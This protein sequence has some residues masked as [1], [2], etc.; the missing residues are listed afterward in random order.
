MG[1]KATTVVAVR[2][3]PH[4]ALGLVEVVESSGEDDKQEPEGKPGG[5]KLETM[6]A[7]MRPTRTKTTHLRCANV[8]DLQFADTLSIWK[9]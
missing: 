8:T 1:C 3:E 5:G 7:A 4:V 9:R 6:V 2:E